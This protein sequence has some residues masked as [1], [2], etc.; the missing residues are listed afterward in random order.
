MWTTSRGSRREQVQ[1]RLAAV[2]SGWVPTSESV[3]QELAG[4]DASRAVVPG[5]ASTGSVAWDD[6]GPPP[7]ARRIDRTILPS[8]VLVVVGAVLGAVVLWLLAW[9]RG[10]AA[11]AP[12]PITWQ[13]GSTSASAS[14]SPGPA[15]T[16]DGPAV[17][18]VDVAGAVRHPGVFELPTGSRVVDAVDAAGGTLRRADT[19]PLNLARV[20]ADGEQVL[21]PERGAAPGALAPT[22]P[23]A[24]TAPAQVD[25]NNATLEQLDALPGIGPVLAQRILDW[26]T[27]NG[28]FTSVD[29]LQDVSG[30]G[31]ATYAD[32]APLVRV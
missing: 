30:I 9:P 21:V 5:T 19:T 27:A 29:Q 26:R 32:L 24:T 20:L 7:P 18:V 23:G 4:T 12:T 31:D 1:R 11:G 2:A 17:V 13:S 22:V 28:G 25:L 3:Q 16:T 6:A 14:A 15:A 10:V 8:L